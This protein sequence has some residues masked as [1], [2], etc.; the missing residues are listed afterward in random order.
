MATGTYKDIPGDHRWVPKRRYAIGDI[1]P[2]RGKVTARFKDYN[3]GRNVYEIDGSILFDDYGYSYTYNPPI[4]IKGLSPAQVA[5]RHITSK[6]SSEVTG[7]SNFGSFDPN[8]VRQTFGGACHAGMNFDVQALWS[9]CNRSDKNRD[10]GMEGWDSENGREGNPAGDEVRRAY[11]GW[12]ISEAS[13]WHQWLRF[14]E[15]LE[16][17][18]INVHDLEFVLQY[19]FIFLE[20]HK[21]WPYRGALLNFLQAS[22]FYYEFAAQS[23]TWF[24][25]VKRGVDPAMAKA[26]ACFGHVK[27]D[28]M[29]WDPR[30]P[31]ANHWAL[32]LNR[33]ALTRFVKRDP[34]SNLKV[35]EGICLW[36]GKGK[37]M[38]GTVVHD[39]RGLAD[40]LKITD[41]LEA[42]NGTAAPGSFRAKATT[43]YKLDDIITNVKKT[44]E[45]LVAA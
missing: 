6:T 16:I 8:G 32:P 14:D 1:M 43:E 26:V 34:V 2:G 41:S 5:L 23:R 35:G 20:P 3:I 33:E 27:D 31:G 7:V 24:E 15:P 28:M 4:D 22:R 37:T 30:V 18:G 19:G 10:Y 45:R 21:V 29:V 9:W 38:Y 42:V 12:I 17:D 40:D 36:A 13:P 25:F 39:S 11:I 44:T